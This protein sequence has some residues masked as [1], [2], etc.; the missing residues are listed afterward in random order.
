MPIRIFHL[1][2]SDVA[3]MKLGARGIS[4]AE[5]RQ[6]PRNRHDVRRD[7]GGQRSGWDRRLLI[8]ET[9]GGRVL[10][11]VIERTHDPNSWEIVTGWT[12]SPR[13]RKVLD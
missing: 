10:T 8:G 12:A 7:L 3:R 13:E 9:D 6:L 2:A 5:A 4:I 1:E 11:L